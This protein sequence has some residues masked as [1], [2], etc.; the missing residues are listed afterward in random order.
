VSKGRSSKASKNPVTLAAIARH[1]GLA[2]CS[3][4]AVLNNTPA[5]RRI[6]QRTKDRVFRAALKLNYRP[7][8]AA[9]AL[10][11][12]RTGL[13]AVIANGFG[14]PEIAALICGAERELRR[15]GYLLVLEGVDAGLHSSHKGLPGRAQSL[16][17]GAI[18]I[19]AHP[20]AYYGIPCVALSTWNDFENPSANAV[21]RG[22]RAAR[23]LLGLI[24]QAKETGPFLPHS[25]HDV[26]ERGF[27][28]CQTM[29]AA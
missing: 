29:G 17:E 22:E 14:R 11:T 23:V 28:S 9:R 4:S 26:I 3:V 12:R 15:R 21:E 25:V 24:E 13:I 19:E 10:R 20:E 8:F 7:N 1:L 27:P 18:T 5:S 2:P 16:A 6:P